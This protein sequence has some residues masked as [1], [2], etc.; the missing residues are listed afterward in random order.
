MPFASIALFLSLAGVALVYRGWRDGQGR[1]SVPGWLCLW[2]AVPLWALTSGWEFGLIYALTLPS[3]LALAV[4]ALVS[5]R[6]EVAATAPSASRRLPLPAL[7]ALGRAGL[8]TLLVLP[9]AGLASGLLALALAYVVAGSADN[10]IALAGVLLPVLWGSLAY[11]LA[12]WRNAG[13]QGA[14]LL[15]AGVLCGLWLALGGVV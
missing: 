12:G 7:S 11:W 14:V 6:R 13:R 10:R 2:L 9:V 1:F 8:W 5:R 15:A 4:V 3:V